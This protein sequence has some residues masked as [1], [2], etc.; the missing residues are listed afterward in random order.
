MTH[1]IG[2]VVVPPTV[3]A[4]F[5]TEPTKYPDLYGKNAR[6]WLAG[7]ELSDYLSTAL[8]RFDE[9][10]QV[11]PR[12][13]EREGSAEETVESAL[14]YAKEL[15][16]SRSSWD[17]YSVER[18]ERFIRDIESAK[19]EQE[20]KRTKLI[21]DAYSGE[22]YWKYDDDGVFRRYTTYNPES[23]WDWWVIGGRW[24]GIYAERQGEPISGLIA[25]I[26]RVQANRADPEKAAALKAVEE[27]VAAAS[28]RLRNREITY[29]EF[30]VIEAK[31]LDC[32]AYI[33][34]FFTHNLVVPSGDTFEWLEIGSTG[35]WGMRSDDMSEDNWLVTMH[36]ALSKL[37]PQSRM[38][39]IDF[40][41]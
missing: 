17:K 31:K 32:E 22:G 18:N 40:H 30:E 41:I 33:P 20:P 29:Q 21:L 7:K 37:D 1:F 13:D 14:K 39:Y 10:R 27:E 12:L 25:E 4:E 16:A 28:A 34:W 38:V 11:E 15:D 35:W 5:S 3:K 2:A 23:R 19:V 9:N 24:E 8:A 26:E 6:E 36:E